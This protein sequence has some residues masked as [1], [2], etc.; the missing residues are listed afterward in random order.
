[1]DTDATNKS[2]DAPQKYIRTFAGDVAVV[3]K[4]GMPDLAPLAPSTV[5]TSPE[6]VTPVAAPTLAPL[7]DEK[8]REETLAGLRA[9]VAEKEA[10]QPQPVRVEAPPPPPKCWGHKIWRVEVLCI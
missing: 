2:G 3:Q 4:G 5:P 9:K 8:V 7:W 1:M 10:E 6:P